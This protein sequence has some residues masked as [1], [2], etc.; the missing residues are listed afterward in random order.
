MINTGDLLLLVASFSTFS[1]LGW[2]FLV[3]KLLET[4]DVTSSVELFPSIRL[5]ASAN[6]ALPGMMEKVGASSSDKLG[7]SAATTSFLHPAATVTT[8]T[9]TT[10]SP[11]LEP[12]SNGASSA[13]V[14]PT[15]SGIGRDYSSGAPRSGSTT[16]LI[17][18]VAGAGGGGLRRMKKLRHAHTLAVSL[19]FS[20]T[21]GLSGTLFELII[22]EILNVL[23]ESTRYLVWKWVLWMVLGMVVLVIPFY[24]C[25]AF[26]TKF[27]RPSRVRRRFSFF[28]SIILW[29]VFF[30][31]FWKLGSHFPIQGV[32][33][34]S[35]Q[36]QQQ[37]QVMAWEPEGTAALHGLHESG[38]GTL[39]AAATLVTGYISM[40]GETLH[41]ANIGN[42]MAISPLMA[43]VG[44]IGVTVMAMIAGFGAVNNPY[45]SLFMFVRKVTT[46]QI[47][48]LE[49]QL[50][51][52]IDLAN[53]KKRRLALLELQ[54]E[55]DHAAQLSSGFVHR[56][57]SRVS[58]T[59]HS[60]SN[61]VEMLRAEIEALE[62]LCMQIYNDLEMLNIERERYKESQT[63]KGKYRNVLG[64]F[65][66]IL[67]IYKTFTSLSN[68]LFYQVKH[69][70]PVSKV[71]SIATTNMN[72]SKVDVALLSQQ[73]SFLFVGV[74]VVFSIRGLL[75]QITKLFK[76]FSSLASPANIVLFLTQT[77]GMYFLAMVL[78]LRMNLPPEYR[79][80]ITG[81]LGDIKF[82]FYKQWFD[83][84]FLM[85]ALASLVFVYFLHQSQKEMV[86]A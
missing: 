69:Q 7:S 20:I 2:N 51:H 78:M 21:M 75:I 4:V 68:I 53:T 8:I 56:M 57:F 46:S 40:A 62:A 15:M 33:D 10:P 52:T 17:G 26:L 38:I 31:A 73:V 76:A 16:P 6:G 70:D 5:D 22:F 24:Q 83:V 30:Y 54:M 71:I 72:M 86:E 35:R 41:G 66:S 44:V 1:Y 12:T 3:R 29:S 65:F 55:E 25:F 61:K 34:P 48:A 63:L 64:Y 14:S 37:Q 45:N 85:S 28:L 59:V 49:R 67:C 82:E 27:G 84:I 32:L 13:T 80:I 50:Q 23:D 18:G 79:K 60:T 19:L 47:V 39:N 74:I 36:Q 42:V 11:T 58:G 77:M 9:T 43:R 81:V